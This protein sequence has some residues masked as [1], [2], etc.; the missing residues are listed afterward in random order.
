M[1]RVVSL[2]RGIVDERYA[3]PQGYRHRS[4]QP[5]VAESEGTEIREVAQRGRDAAFKVV[6]AE[7]E[8]SKGGKLAERSE[9]AWSGALDEESSEIQGCYSVVSDSDACPY[10]YMNPV[11]PVGI[12]APP[13][14]S[15]RPAVPIVLS[16]FHESQTVVNDVVVRARHSYIWGESAEVCVNERPDCASLDF[17]RAQIIGRL[18]LTRRNSRSGAAGG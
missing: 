17:L 15:A 8:N 4:G 9:P 16:E 7:I 14:N 11:G 2:L 10:G 3:S 18:A 6:V 5:V 1:D 13:L 12:D